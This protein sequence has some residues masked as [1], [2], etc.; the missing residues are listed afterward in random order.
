MTLVWSM[1]K[2]GPIARDALDC[3]L[4]FDAIR[5]ADDADASTVDAP[6][7]L[8][9]RDVKKLRIGYLKTDFEKPYANSTNDAAT[10]EV[11]RKQGIELRAVE[12][13]RAAKEPDCVR[14]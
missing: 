1:D 10:L 4:V 8:R 11:L 12:L 7:S 14:P 3:G 5:G 6:F 2:I 13:P 9:F